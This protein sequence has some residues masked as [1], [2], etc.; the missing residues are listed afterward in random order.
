M[1]NKPIWFL[2]VDG[3]INCFPAPT[4]SQLMASQDWRDATV[5]GYKVWWREELVHFI[6]RVHREG[7]AEI[8]WL[9]TW[10]ERAPELL[11]PA[12][13]LDDFAVAPKVKG[14]DF[15]FLDWWKW[16]TVKKV[17]DARDAS[18]RLV[19]TDDDVDG[20]VRG[21]AT[22]KFDKRGLF[23]TPESN[24]GLTSEDQDLIET[25]L[26]AHEVRKPR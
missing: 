7:L 14:S 15:P 11:A 18:Q 21:F 17:L 19:W 20:A 16:N 2:D 12:L 8:M 23:I 4:H 6:N 22:S 26:T 3:V 13:G 9:T 10:E 25:F 24:P 5:N 1:K